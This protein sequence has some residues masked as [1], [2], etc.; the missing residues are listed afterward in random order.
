MGSSIKIHANP[1]L[2]VWAREESGL[3]PEEL[4][5]KLHIPVDRFRQW[6]NTG[7]NIPLGILKQVANFYKRQLA[8]FCLPTPP[9]KIKKP[10]DFRNLAKDQ[11]G[12]SGEALLIV[13]R[14]SKYL[15]LAF[16]L[17]GEEYWKTKYNWLNEADN[18]LTK[19]KNIT[20]AEI[21]G[22]LRNALGIS[23]DQ[24]KKFRSYEA[25]FKAWRNAV[26][27]KLGIFVFQF[28]MP[29]GE[30]DGFS[31]AFEPPYAIVLNN[32]NNLPQR[33]IFTLFHELGHILKHQSGICF[34]DLYRENQLE[35]EYQ[36]NDFA[37]KFL[38]PDNNVY[39]VDS[40]E[41]L[42]KLSQTYKVSREVYLRRSFENELI[43]K[44]EFF[45]HLKTIREIAKTPK[46]KK[47]GFAVSPSVTSKS[48][49]GE[50]FY[51]LV[52]DAAYN[53][54]IDF[55]TATDVLNLKINSILNA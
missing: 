29:E 32:T 21:T 49:R 17:E 43:S 13:R 25:A 48:Q 40:V 33:K 30:M 41:E 54:R 45:N 12:L 14:T 18:L 44:R 15:K 50:A 37:G 24:Q 6:E 22:W 52:V 35:M 27:K 55:S 8:V 11:S 10:G 16:E 51:N 36:C 5:V 46:A 3:T 20:D 26:E 28:P 2:L 34:T 4:A 39:P 9:P 38:V 42:T 19:K 23:L 53:N 31:Y 47:E 7:K 1:E